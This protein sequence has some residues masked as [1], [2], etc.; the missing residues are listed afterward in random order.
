MQTS[1]ILNYS[2]YK[3]NQALWI[4]KQLRERYNPSGWTMITNE[5]YTIDLYLSYLDI[6]GIVEQ[7]LGE[8]IKFY[9][10]KINPSSSNGYFYKEEIHKDINMLV[11]TVISDYLSDKQKF[12][13][14]IKENPKM[15]MLT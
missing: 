7:K 8:V 11:D 14:N 3:I 6:C 1:E 10:S 9:Q 2:N 4:Q 12:F 15:Y 5:Q 13:Q